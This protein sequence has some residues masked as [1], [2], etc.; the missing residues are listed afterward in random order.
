[1]VPIAGAATVTIVEAFDEDSQ[2]GTYHVT[3]DSATDALLAFP[4]ENK[5]SVE[6]LAVSGTSARAA[7]V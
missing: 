4:V 2:T 1:M 3:N 5:T 6:A 7:N